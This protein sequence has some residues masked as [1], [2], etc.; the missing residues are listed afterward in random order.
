MHHLHQTGCESCLRQ[1]PDYSGIFLS[2]Y[3][4]FDPTGTCLLWLRHPIE[5]EHV[6]D[7]GRGGIRTQMHQFGMIRNNV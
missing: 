4:G 1:C 2:F 3:P 5:N 7:G 6:N